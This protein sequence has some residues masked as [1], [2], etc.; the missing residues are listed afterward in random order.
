MPT[1]VPTDARMFSWAIG[2]VPDQFPI[3]SFVAFLRGRFHHDTPSGF[4]ALS[5]L[6]RFRISRLPISACES[7]GRI[8]S[9]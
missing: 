8:V 6:S 5:S 9:I 7:I 4:P 3:E 2:L 1:E